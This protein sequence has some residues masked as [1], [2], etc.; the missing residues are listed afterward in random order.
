M[1]LPDRTVEVAVRGRGRPL[2]VLEAGCTCDFSAWAPVF[3]DLA[4]RSE[5]FAYSR[6]GYGRSTLVATP[7]DVTTEARELRQLLRAIGRGPPY[8]LVGHSLGGLI[9]Q[10]FAAAHPEEVA[11]L[12][13]VDPTPL[14]LIERMHRDLPEALD[15][16]YDAWAV[17]VGVARLEFEHLRPPGGGRFSG[18]PYGGPVIVLGAWMLEDLGFKS[19]RRYHRLH[20]IPRTV[21]RYAK[22][23]LRKVACGHYIQCQRPLAV[24]DAVD[25]VLARA[26]TP[27]FDE[28]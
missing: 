12:V 24:I 26:R 15:A 28:E 1:S 19:V 27:L 18:E 16:F 2:I 14:D 3:A 20:R 4:Q 21:A 8:L 7:R 13:L 9:V 5:T 25:E 22:A 10:A 17:A 6:P 23:E 11:G